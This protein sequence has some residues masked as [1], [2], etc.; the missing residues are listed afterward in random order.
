MLQ[1]RKSF[2]FPPS[3]C[4]LK[5]AIFPLLVWLIEEFFQVG[6]APNVAKPTFGSRAWSTIFDMT[7]KSQNWRHF[8]QISWPVWRKNNRGF[9]W[10][11]EET[12]FSHLS[13]VRRW[14][15]FDLIIPFDVTKWI[16]H[17]KANIVFHFLFWYCKYDRKYC[18]VGDFF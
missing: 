9:T 3:K 6:S 12:E 7:V 14:Y 1:G 4:I 15:L 16:K 10:D 17:S 5:Y 8:G 2:D 11:S 18:V 13:H